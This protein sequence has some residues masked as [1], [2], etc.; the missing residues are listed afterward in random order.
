MIAG[1]DPGQKGAIAFIGG[2]LGVSWMPMP[3]AGEGHGKK[4]IIGHA[5]AEALRGCSYVAVEQVGAMPGQGVTSM[6]QFGRG[7]GRIEGV[8]QAL[9]LPYALVHPKTWKKAVLNGLPHDKEGAIAFAR[10]QWPSVSL[11]APGCRT[12]HDG[13]ADALCLAWYALHLNRT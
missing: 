7:L 6:F 3:V 1:I 12:P 8:L 5:V 10:R 11:I 9:A 2:T 4:G 13:A